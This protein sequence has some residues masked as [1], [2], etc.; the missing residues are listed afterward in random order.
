MIYPSLSSTTA[1]G[2]AHAKQA[3]SPG[4]INWMWEDIASSDTPL[5][6]QCYLS[7]LQSM[8]IDILAE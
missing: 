4:T 2:V 6:N 7:S 8:L 1:N 3:V 5:S